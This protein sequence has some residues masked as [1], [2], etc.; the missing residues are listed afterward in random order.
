MRPVVLDTSVVLPAALSPRGYRRRFWVLLAFGALA[1]RR[2]LARLEADA[3]R[4]EAGAAGSE[5]GGLPV[6]AAAAGADERYRRL[7]ELLPAGCPEDWRLV[8]S[9]PLLEE[10]VRKLREAG[11]KL[12]PA[13]SPYGIEVVRHQI[14]SVCADMT[15]DFDP[16][17][18]P[19]Y[20][21]DRNDD[22]VVHTALLADAAW[23]I[24]DDR[25]HICT[26][27]DGMT[28]Y[29]LP[30]RDRRV[31]AVTFSRFLEHLTDIDLD[32]I[33]PALLAVAFAPLT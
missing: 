16:K 9:R 26:D 3:L 18:I 21:A 20:T 33:D 31:S 11:P 27:P 14:E 10:Y 30:G 24:A 25:R 8:G 23:L 17:V 15:E 6:D 1:A 22:P 32:Q 5:R 4:R 2:N 29:E 28:E 7:R 13:L 19:R 12:D